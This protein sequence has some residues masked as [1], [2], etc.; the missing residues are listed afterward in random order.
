M[1]L[2]FFRYRGGKAGIGGGGSNRA[3]GRKKQQNVGKHMFVPDQEEMV[4]IED[5]VAPVEPSTAVLEEEPKKK[6][7][8]KSKKKT[9]E[10]PVA[11]DEEMEASS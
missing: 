1:Y 10:A 7:T 9:E 8:K 6:K 4:S 3:N 11:M 2:S 5:Y